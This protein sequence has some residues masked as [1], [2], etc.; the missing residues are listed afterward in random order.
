MRVYTLPKDKNP[1]SSRSHSLYLVVVNRTR[2]DARIWCSYF[3]KMQIVTLL[4][5]I[6]QTL[7]FRIFAL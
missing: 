4:F 6:F 3:V 5:I 1:G 2:M 7:K